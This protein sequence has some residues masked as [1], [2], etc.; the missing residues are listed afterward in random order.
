MPPYGAKAV[1]VGQSA[2]QF[3]DATTAPFLVKQ[4]QLAANPSFAYLPMLC[5]IPPCSA[6]PVR[7]VWLSSLARPPKLIPVRVFFGGGFDSPTNYPISRP[8]I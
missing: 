5:H 4:I 8:Y 3:S 2:S 6:S 7:S 1:K